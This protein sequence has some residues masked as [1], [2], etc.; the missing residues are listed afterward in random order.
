MRF[1]KRW[2]F[3]AA[4]ILAVALLPLASFAADTW[5]DPVTG[6][7]FVW[8]PKGCFQMGSPEYEKNRESNERR[9]EV[10]VD[11]YWLGKYEVTNSQYKKFRPD[12][13]ADDK[14]PVTDISWQDAMHFSQ[15][16]SDKTGKKIRLPTEAEWEYAARAGTSTAY[17]WGDNW[18]SRHN[19]A[20]TDAKKPVGSHQPNAYG[21]YDMLGNVWEWT[22]SSYD[23]GYGG[24]ER[25][26]A[27]LDAGGHRVIRGGSWLTRPRSV[28]SANRYYYA[29]VTR[30]DNAG[31]RLARIP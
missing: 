22:A 26:V 3:R 11:G 23:S 16:L 31:F 9:H 29:P 8:I 18:E 12:H 20:S 2:V 1:P 27:S 15:W 4:A 25:Q 17:F 19:F 7:K 28:R 10:C 24:A 5:T 30:L 13:A 6:M 14:L 21:L